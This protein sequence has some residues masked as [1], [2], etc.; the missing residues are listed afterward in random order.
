MASG[1]PERQLQQRPEPSRW[2]KTERPVLGDVH[3]SDGRL[4]CFQVFN[5]GVDL[6]RAELEPGHGRTDFSTRIRNAINRHIEHGQCLSCTLF[7]RHVQISDTQRLCIER[8]N[9]QIDGIGRS[10]T[11][12]DFSA[13]CCDFRRLAA[14]GSSFQSKGSRFKPPSLSVPAIVT[15]ALSPVARLVIVMASEALS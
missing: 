10:G 2:R 13:R 14:G 6:G 12:N 9:G 1:W 8:S 4:C 11:N 7:R 3:V 15:S 5:A